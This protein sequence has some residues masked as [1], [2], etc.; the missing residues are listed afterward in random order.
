MKFKDLVIGKIYQD[1]NGI[2]RFTGMRNGNIAE[3]EELGFD[4]NDELFVIDNTIY[5]TEND[6]ARFEVV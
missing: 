3:F 4:N 5:K 2:Y 6:M 1:S